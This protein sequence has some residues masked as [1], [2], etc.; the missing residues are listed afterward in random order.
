VG[1]VV[2]FVVGVGVAMFYFRAPNDAGGIDHNDDGVLDERWRSSPSG[3]P[4]RT[5]ID[6]NFDDAADVVWSFDRHGKAE[7]G[8]SDDDF[9]G[10]FETQFRLRGG[11]VYLSQVDTDGNSVPD[12]KSLS[13]FGVLTT[14]EILDQNSGKPVRVETFRLGKLVQSDVDTDRDGKLDRRYV[15]DSFGEVAATQDI[16]AQAST[17]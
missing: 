11:Q 14:E 4:I 7:S 3:T 13:K 2:G 8:E 10:V 17:E 5:E 6:R 15:Y 1:G 9:D 16:G 12:L